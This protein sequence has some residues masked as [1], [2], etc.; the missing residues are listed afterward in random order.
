V[1]G[2]VNEIAVAKLTTA[3]HG[4]AATRH[5]FRS[6]GIGTERRRDHVMPLHGHAGT[7]VSPH[8][9]GGISGAGYR[10]IAFSRPLDIAHCRSTNSTYHHTT[11]LGMKGVGPLMHRVLIKRS[12]L[13]VL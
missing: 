11:A 2:D 10:S 6:K 5:C 9:G 1:L 3:I 4:T 12:A 7:L 13:G 8:C